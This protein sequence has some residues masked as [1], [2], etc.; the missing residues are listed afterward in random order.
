MFFTRLTRWVMIFLF[1]Y[2][3]LLNVQQ[4]ACTA[5][6]V[7]HAVPT[8]GYVVE[9]NGGYQE[10]SFEPWDPIPYE[11]VW[12][13]AVGVIDAVAIFVA[14]NMYNGTVKWLRES[15]SERIKIH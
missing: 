1:V 10:M 7:S 14:V 4:T 2:G 3:V 5:W 15:K 9:W 13:I 6:Y 11:R 8:G 12:M